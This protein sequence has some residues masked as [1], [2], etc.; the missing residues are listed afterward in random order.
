M[1][2]DGIY[3]QVLYPSVTLAGAKIYGDEREL[4]LACVRAYNDWL[5]EFCDGSR[6]PADRPGHP[7]DDRRRRR[8]RRDGARARRSA[9]AACVISAFPNGT[10]EPPRRGRAVLGARAGDR[11][12]GRA[13][14]SAA[15]SPTARSGE[16]TRRARAVHG[17][18]PAPRS[19]AR[20]R[21]RSSRQLLF[22][23]VFER[24]PTLKLLLVE[25]NIGWIPTL[26]EQIDDMFLR[27]RL[28]TERR[29]QLPT[30]AEPHLPP[31]LLGDV[32]DRH[33][34]HGAAPPAERRPPHVVDRLPAHRLRLAEQPRHDRAHLP[35]RAEATR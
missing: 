13:C 8:R 25:S 4:Q 10:L 14:T 18:A 3:A 21:C 5:A 17:R 26:L 19:R 7:P 11:H 28:F 23:G 6:R 30:H 35:R 9:T 29:E 32:H 31:Q 15:S 27:Y 1:D 2:A 34:R 20:T 22:S 33:G 24:F 16:P 12:A